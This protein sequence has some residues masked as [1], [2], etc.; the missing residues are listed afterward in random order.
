MLCCRHLQLKN[1]IAELFFE[2]MNNVTKAAIA[3]AL[4]S[5]RCGR[6]ADEHNDTK[7]I[8]PFVRLINYKRAL[9]KAIIS[10]LPSNSSKMRKL[11]SVN[12]TDARARAIRH[13]YK[14]EAEHGS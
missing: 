1:K 6:C 11:P 14:N 12:I 13:E 5:K 7:G 10:I 3:I 4:A 9:L 2:T 8:W